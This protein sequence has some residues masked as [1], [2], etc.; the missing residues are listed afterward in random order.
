MLLRGRLLWWAVLAVVAGGAVVSSVV[1]GAGAAPKGPASA[2]A[3]LELRGLVQAEVGRIEAKR[4]ALRTPAARSLR[5][6]SRNEFRGQSD[7]DA[8]RMARRLWPSVVGAKPAGGVLMGAGDRMEGFMGTD[9]VRIRRADGKRVVAA[10]TAPL[11]VKG[12]DGQSQAIDLSLTDR[13]AMFAPTRGAGSLVIAKHLSGGVMLGGKVGFIPLGS[14]NS[15]G[16]RM[17][18]SVM[19]PNM[20]TDADTMARPLPDGAEI[21]TQLRSAGS[22][23]TLAFRFTMPVGATVRPSPMG[24]HGVEVVS[25]TGRVLS[26]VGA[27]S[28]HDADGTPVPVSFKL[29]GDVLRVHVSHRHGDFHYPIL[30]DPVVTDPNITGAPGSVAAGFWEY[31]TLGSGGQCFSPFAGNAYLGAGQY[32][33]W[34]GPGSCRI[35]QYDMGYFFYPAPGDASVVTVNYGYIRQDNRPNTPMCTFTR[36]VENAASGF[37][38]EPNT[39]K[40]PSCFENPVSVS[41]GVYGGYYPGNFGE[42]GQYSTCANGPAPNNYCD[43]PYFLAYASGLTAYVEDDKAPVISTG[44]APPSG[45]TN[46]DGAPI[47]AN[48]VDSGIGTEYATLSAQTGST[49]TVLDNE[50]ANA[51][52]LCPYGVRCSPNLPTN[53]TV[54]QLPEG[55]STITD[56]AQDVAGNNSGAQQVATARV[57]RTP[58][59]ADLSGKLHDTA[60]KPLK[61]LA[62]LAVDAIDGTPG[63]QTSGVKQIDVYVDDVLQ[64]SQP[65]PQPCDTATSADECSL[66]LDDWMFDSTHFQNGNRTIRV[67]VTDYA[68]NQASQQ[69]VVD[70]ENGAKLA[71]D[72]TVQGATVNF[73]VYSLGAVFEN[74]PRTSID[75]VCDT[76]DPAL[77]SHGLQRENDVTV[78]YGTCVPPVDMSKGD[79]TASC[80]LPLEIQTAPAC[81]R[82]RATYT[83]DATGTPPPRTD[84][85]IRGVPAAW[86]DDSAG[87]GQSVRLEVYTGLVT[88]IIFGTDKQMMLDAANSMLPTQPNP[89]TDPDAQP[90]T[91]NP[92]QTLPT[93]AVGALAG[94]LLCN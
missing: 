58:P 72:C 16:T 34:L 82:N 41:Y 36:F 78:S 85:T 74:L 32:I 86:F 11:A 65:Q 35:Y 79:T 71:M 28:A 67:V 89:F 13:G 47:S 87:G 93:T 15:P 44:Q 90:H 4:A 60:N 59:T 52:G 3:D 43:Y 62:T 69:W 38:A 83:D 76:A 42:W 48:A 10:S 30:V 27:I 26:S 91:P 84:L 22:P 61:G 50:N 21:F 19:W 39:T 5:Q 68:N 66:S 49:S 57:D 14:R 92:S 24:Q 29:D 63:G 88:V 8:G 75:R 20:A 25:A 31:F 81:E 53:A 2:A 54:G 33:R 18:D 73:S 94:T 45:W 70:V 51:R 9:A 40:V 1:W 56:Q 55:I 80:E 77:V 23:E 7:G 46:N 12:A 64:T 17:G 37:I 6:A